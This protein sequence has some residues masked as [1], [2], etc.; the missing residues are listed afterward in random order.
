MFTQPSGLDYSTTWAKRSLMKWKVPMLSSEHHRTLRYGETREV[1]NGIGCHHQEMEPLTVEAS[2]CSAAD[3]LS[4][5]RPGARI[6]AVEEYIKRLKKLEDLAMEI[7]G[8]K[9]YMLCR[10]DGKCGWLCC[11]K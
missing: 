10:P 5:S 1:A 4:A 7:P 8:S 6:E 3:A 11:R 2:L 9:K